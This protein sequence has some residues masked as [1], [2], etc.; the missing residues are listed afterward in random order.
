MSDVDDTKCPM[1]GTAMSV[2]TASCLQCGES[3]TVSPVPARRFHWRII[4]V[5]ALGALSGL[6]VAWAL[7][8]FTLTVVFV[9]I[10]RWDLSSPQI[11][12]RG[13]V[14][15]IGILVTSITLGCVAILLW[16]RYWWRAAVGSALV[17]AV[18]LLCQWVF[19]LTY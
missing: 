18:Y 12:R 7:L 16:K 6:G 5:V 11:L 14:Q 2:D 13:I 19:L 15:P 3:R 1:C 10:G 17:V 4:P 9:A 8:G